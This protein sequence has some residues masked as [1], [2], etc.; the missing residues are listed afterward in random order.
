MRSRRL[1]PY[2]MIIVAMCILLPAYGFSGR[3]DNGW[4]GNW[5]KDLGPELRV[6]SSDPSLVTGGDALV[7]VSIPAGASASKIKVT[8]N[9]KDVTD[10]LTLDAA[11][12]TLRG[13][14][15][16]MSIGDNRLAAHVSGRGT[17]TLTLTNYPIGG[18][19]FSGPQLQPWLCT[20]NAMGLG[21]PIDAQCNAPTKYEYFYMSNAS[22]KFEAY[23]PNNPPPAT[24]IATTT[25]DQNVTMNYIVRRETGTANRGIYQIA[26]L[27]DPSQ[28]WTALKPQK[29]WN[30]KVFIPLTGGFTKNWSQSLIETTPSSLILNDMALKR[31]FMTAKNTQMQYA[32]NADSVRG[33]ESLMM[34]KE[35]IAK[36]YGSIRYT[37]AAGGSGGSMEQMLTTNNYPGMLQGIIPQSMYTDTWAAPFQE[38]YDCHLL[39]NYFKTTSPTL[40]T[41]P[42]QR[43][44]VYGHIDETT[45]NFFETIFTPR[46]MPSMDTGL[47]AAQ[48]YNATTNPTGARGAL[49]DYQVNYLGRRPRN[50]WSAPETA[51]GFGFAR[52]EYDNVGVQYGLKA[53]IDGKI[54]AEQ[55]VD[56]NEKVDG[57]DIDFNRVPT[58]TTGDPR[59]AAIMYRTGF[60]NDTRQLDTVAI[61]GPRPPDPDPIA[62]HSMYH[63]FITR[64]RLKKAHGS[65]DN[66]VIW[67]IPGYNIGLPDEL[68]FVSM[69]RWLTAIEADKSSDSL[70]AKVI[71][72]KPS[73]VV[74]GCWLA[75]QP[76]NLGT[77][78]RDLKEC[79]SPGLYPVHGSPRTVAASGSRNATFITKCQPKPLSKRDYPPI[80]TD[81][82][83][84]RLRA[85]FPNG[86]CDWTEPDVA[87]TESVPWLTFKAGPG[88]KPIPIFPPEHD[89]HQEHD[90]D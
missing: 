27:F 69:D 5:E 59:T 66:Q 26:V 71:K 50:L 30:H 32:T 45:C 88:G 76:V 16:G 31:G 79:T 11:T 28:P 41:D 15:S 23:N 87:E 44:A 85:T 38:I 39:V 51:A 84:V 86:V 70:A 1:F 83:W 36:Q 20:T 58:R 53:L 74:D 37:F 22:G 24:D 2:L 4:K 80:F 21:D 72:N 40:W 33:A 29:G 12:H 67:I 60:F 52:S 64:D 25:T 54:S 56:M 75:G 90:R 48:T 47:P 61:L 78:I 55:F 57:T 73:D 18:P 68:S 14:I 82:Q 9:G 81:A 8:L 19:V 34:L 17:T 3:E 49:Q 63:S 65:A 43:I 77:Q 13:L 89:E 35:H 46:M 10:Q 62:S 6:L 42:G 7:S